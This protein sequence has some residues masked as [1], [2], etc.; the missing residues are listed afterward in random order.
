MAFNPPPPPPLIIELF[1]GFSKEQ[2]LYLD[3]IGVGRCQGRALHTP[4]SEQNSAA[5]HR[6]WCKANNISYGYLFL[7]GSGSI[8]PPP[9]QKNINTREKVP[10]P[11]FTSHLPCNEYIDNVCTKKMGKIWMGFK[12]F[13]IGTYIRWLL[14]T[15]CARMMKI[16]SFPKKNR[17]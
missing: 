12:V 3:Q 7:Y 14:R 1:C 17:I 13:L 6:L 2:Y 16:R 11:Y 10:L 4:P 5:M 15:C 8:N 9:P